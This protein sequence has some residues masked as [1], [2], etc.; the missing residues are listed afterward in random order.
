MT[1]YKTDEEQIEQIKAWWSSYGNTVITAALVV[2]GTWIGVS[3]WNDKQQ[4]ERDSVS[5]LFDNV[6]EARLI[7]EASDE[8]KAKAA[9][10]SASI[11]GDH[12]SSVYALFA[13]L[14]NAKSAV[15]SGNLAG[16]ESELEWVLSQGETAAEIKWIAQLRLA[17]VKHALDKSDEALKLLDT[18]E[19]VSTFAAA[20]EEARGDIYYA[21]G[22]LKKAKAAYQKSALLAGEQGAARPDLRMKLDSLVAVDIGDDS[23]ASDEPEADKDVQA[24][25]GS[26]LNSE[27]EGDA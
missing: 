4:Q 10:L 6:V 9:E 21:R 14:F 24:A 19:D 18:N 27:K 26:A 7:P 16:A 25:S 17:R 11:K 8:Q 1:E 15:E 5:A 2:A 13:A 20:Y 3:W 12:G 23:A 22:D